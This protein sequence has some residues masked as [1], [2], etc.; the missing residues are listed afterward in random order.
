MA[1]NASHTGAL[2]CSEVTIDTKEDVL[3]GPSQTLMSGA[4]GARTGGLQTSALALG[5]S[6]AAIDIIE[7]EAANRPELSPASEALSQ[8]HDTLVS[9]LLDIAEKTV[10]G[11]RQAL[12]LRANDLVTRATKAALVATKGRGY[13]RDAQAGI[14]CRQALFFLVWSSPGPVQLASINAL[15]GL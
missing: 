4:L 5:L 1:L 12:R 7:A 15:A 9:D 10:A 14:Y 3:A 13:G 8:T 2:R 11:D 6:R